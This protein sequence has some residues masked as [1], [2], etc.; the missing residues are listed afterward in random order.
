MCVCVC[1]CFYVC[2]RVCVCVCMHACN[3]SE[4]TVC[5]S[6]FN[7]MNELGLAVCVHVFVHGHTQRLWQCCH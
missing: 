5:F 7:D 1:R 3:L 6:F 2:L 4:V